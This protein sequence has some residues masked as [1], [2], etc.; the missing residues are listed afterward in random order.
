MCLLNS[1]LRTPAHRRLVLGSSRIRLVFGSAEVWV[2]MGDQG[3]EGRDSFP[4][5]ASR[6]EGYGPHR[7]IVPPIVNLP[8]DKDQ[9]VQDTVVRRRGLPPNSFLLSCDSRIAA[10]LTPAGRPK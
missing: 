4:L 5:R 10:H 6:I 3:K 7:L 1:R 8:A 9:R 2:V